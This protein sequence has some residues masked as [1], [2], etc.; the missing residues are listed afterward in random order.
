MTWRRSSEVIGGVFDIKF[1]P[2]IVDRCEGYRIRDIDGKEYID[3]NASWAVANVGYGNKKIIDAVCEQFSKTSSFSLTSYYHEKS[4]KLAELLL[5]LV[6]ES[7]N[8]KVIFGHS[9]SDINDGIFKLLPYATKKNKII[10]FLGSYHGQTYGSFSLSGHKAEGWLNPAGGVVKVPYP[11]CYRC[12]FSLEYPECKI[13]CVRFIEEYI[14][15]TVAPAED[16][17]IVFLEP[18]QSDGGDIVPPEEFH[19]RLYKLCKRNGIYYG[20][21]EVKVG[22]AR[23]GKFFGFEHYGIKPDFITVGKPMGGGFPISA[24]IGVR[25]VLDYPGAFHLSTI[26][27]H[28]AGCSASIATIEYIKENK[29]DRNAEKMGDRLIKGLK[30]IAENRDIIGDVRG[31]GLIVGVELVRDRESKEPASKECAMLTYRCWELGLV[32]AYV[33]L[34]SNVVEITP[35]LVIDEEGI[36]EG[37]NIFDQ[38]LK[39]IVEGR[40]DESKV[41]EFAGW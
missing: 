41:K 18:I 20:V 21:D 1:Y 15:E 33:G 19:D 13:H 2:L 8:K 32:L 29:L 40:F 3:F 5:S 25:E 7:E 12:P 39:D 9:G 37:L 38:A 24:C 34:Y 28:P 14:F 31:K 4:I 10:T 35:P 23:T 16:V 26:A 27:G 11:Y 17:S 22:F 36:D 30:E 6:P